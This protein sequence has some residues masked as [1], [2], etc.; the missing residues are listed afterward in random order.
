MSRFFGALIAAAIA[1][2]MAHWYFKSWFL[3]NW[4]DSVDRMKIAELL[5]KDWSLY[6][7]IQFYFFG[8]CLVFLLII[9]P[10]SLYLGG[11]FLSLP[12]AWLGRKLPRA[13]KIL[14]KVSIPFCWLFEKLWKLVR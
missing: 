8:S 14:E 9:L 12:L 1:V 3:I 4:F 11:R 7:P 5:A 6:R 10:G 13:R 2:G